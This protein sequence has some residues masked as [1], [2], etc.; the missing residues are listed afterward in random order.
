MKPVAILKL[1]EKH[2]PPILIGFALY[3]SLK[4][5]LEAVGFINV[6]LNPFDT[7]SILSVG[8]LY[9][10]E[11]HISMNHLFALAPALI[12]LSFC[13]DFF[14]VMLGTEG[15]TGDMVMGIS[16]LIGFCVYLIN[17]AC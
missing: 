14:G 12:S 10:F 13:H 8:F 7:I 3:S 4:F 17:F 15:F 16:I 1:I 5:I 11:K 9:L 6:S 2:T